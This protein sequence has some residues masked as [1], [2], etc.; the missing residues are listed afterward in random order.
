MAAV[1]E[2]LRERLLSLTTLQADVLATGAIV[3]ALSAEDLA[4][5]VQVSKR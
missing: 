5:F 1:V 2:G 4:A 3:L